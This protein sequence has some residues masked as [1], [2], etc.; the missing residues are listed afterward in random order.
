M[1][2]QNFPVLRSNPLTRSGLG[3][4]I[5]SG[6]YVKNFILFGFSGRRPGRSRLKT[7]GQ[8]ESDIQDIPIGGC[9][10]G[11]TGCSQQ[12]NGA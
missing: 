7:K 2:L 10:P 1:Q 8:N 5:Y 9:I 3:E 6:F 11:K 4:I 12:G